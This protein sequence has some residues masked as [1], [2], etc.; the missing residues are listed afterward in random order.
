MHIYTT[1][2]KYQKEKLKK[3]LMIISI[4]VEKYFDKIQ[5]SFMIKNSQ[6]S[7]NRG[8][9]P[10]HNKGYI[11]QA[12]SQHHTNGQKLKVFPLDQEQDRDVC[13]HLSYST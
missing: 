7:G 13:F 12:H 3:N 4:D 10:K 9:I 2:I 8:N 6:Q 5:H 1:I 11:S